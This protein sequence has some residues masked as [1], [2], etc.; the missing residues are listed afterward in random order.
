MFCCVA[1]VYMQWLTQL[2]YISAAYFSLEALVQNEFTGRVNDCSAGLEGGLVDMLQ[3]GLTNATPM[4]RTV[5][6]RM[7]EP[8][9]G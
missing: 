3:A 8:Q 7:K 9:P 5:L 4:Q 1:Q 6:N 2:R